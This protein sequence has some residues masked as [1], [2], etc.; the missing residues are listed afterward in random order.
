MKLNTNDTLIL[1]CKIIYD[2][3]LKQLKQFNLYDKKGEVIKFQKEA[4][5]G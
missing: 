3:V 4:L 1:K 5:I 2:I